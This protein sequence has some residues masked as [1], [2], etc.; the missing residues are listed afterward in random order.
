[1]IPW[2]CP[3]KIELFLYFSWFCAAKTPEILNIQKK[4]A[5]N[6]A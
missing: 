4:I 6:V 5:I 3:G 1:M 2:P